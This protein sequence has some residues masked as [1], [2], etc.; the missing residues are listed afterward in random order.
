MADVHD[1]LTRS[2]NMSQ[3][4]SKNTKPEIFVRK[5]LFANGYR[6]KLHESKL[7]GTPDIVLPK[8]RT[9]I[10]IH[11]CFWHGHDNC[12]FFVMPKTRTKFWFD[13]IQSNKNR[14]EKNLLALRNEGWNVLSIFECE[15]KGLKKAETLSNILLHLKKNTG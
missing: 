3:I 2:Y 12:P 1:K 10:F 7:P 8:Y 5:F 4:K 13:K 9:V 15:L 6:F 11:G 14:D